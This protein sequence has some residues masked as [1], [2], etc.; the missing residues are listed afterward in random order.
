M[1]EHEIDVP[2][3]PVVFVGKVPFLVSTLDQA[4]ATTINLAI[5][6]IAEPVRLSN[7]YCVAL[8]ENDS[9]YENLYA[10]GGLTFPDGTP[11]VWFMRRFK[12]SR[13]SQRVRGPSLFGETLRQ[14]VG[15]GV[16]HYFLGTSEDTLTKMREQA[17]ILAPGVKIA[18]AYAPPYAE[19]DTDFVAK[20]AREV[21]DTDAD[22]VWVAL[23]TPKQDF[24]SAQ[25]APATGRPCVG[26]GA[27]FDFLAGT[28]REAPVWIQRSGFEWLFRLS[29]DPRRLWRRYL[30]GN[31]RFLTAATKGLFRRS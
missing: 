5:A 12:H 28:V 14:G 7:A 26:V 19:L 25:L 13:K 4:V 2:R 10:S 27:A 3:R 9:I 17:Q 1:T 20:C 22:L 31:I 30:I 8:A 24:L 11:I 21:T 16:K 29:Q 18:G 15:S 6:K 23:G